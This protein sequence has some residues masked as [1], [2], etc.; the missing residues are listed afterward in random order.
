MPIVRD[1]RNDRRR[2]V[3]RENAAQAQASTSSKS[4]KRQA[5][6]RAD[7]TTRK[8]AG[9]SQ[10]VRQACGHRLVQLIPVRP[11]SFA[12]VIAVSL[13]VPALLSTAHY[14]VNVNGRLPWYGHP[15]AL[16]LDVNYPRSL[17]S[18]VT[19]QLWLLCLG[20]TILTFQLR[21]HK[22]DDYS[23]EYRL[24][25]WLVLTCIV[26]SLEASTGV[27]QL[28]S[29]ALDSWST[30][31]LGWSGPAIVKATLAVLIGMLGLRL[32][33]ELKSAPA[34]IVFVMI[35]LVAW[36]ISSALAQPEFQVNLSPQ[37]RIWAKCSLWLCGLTSIW[38]ASLTNL[39]HVYIEA[40]QRFLS[41]GRILSAGNS[42]PLSQRLRAAMPS[43]PQRGESA[44]RTAASG[45]DG[46]TSRW[47]LPRLRRSR[48]EVAEPATRTVRS[49]ARKPKEESAPDNSRQQERTEPGRAQPA[50][51]P[52][53]STRSAEAAGERAD[54][55]PRRGLGGFFKRGSTTDAL[56]TQEQTSRSSR[57]EPKQQREESR[58]ASHPEKR[59]RDE[60]GTGEKKPGR[61]TGWLRR[62]KHSEDAEE[63]RKI[64]R[65]ESRAKSERAS[66]VQSEKSES[67][68]KSQN[69]AEDGQATEKTPR[70]W[71]PR[72]PKPKM[73]KL[74][75]PSFGWLPK[76]SLSA[77]RLKPPAEKSKSEKPA[78]SQNRTSPSGKLPSTAASSPASAASGSEPD[79]GGDNGRPL[80]KAERK[81]LRR[82]QQQNRAA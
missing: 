24:W 11:L 71:V 17:A 16:V 53:T 64:P 2:R 26:G 38:L 59:K 58:Q 20:S 80:T 75:K 31:T 52:S 35:G 4:S 12:V 21:R 44:K 70:R 25:F 60:D 18:W 49:K 81:R 19:G 62:P 6:N 29:I 47:R 56:K 73:P 5:A 33:T 9:Y 45:E 10:D 51:T 79:D 40:Q 28:F 27:I 69:A 42:Q 55:N 23:G 14:L 48:D 72:V 13:L 43:L 54:T 57:A 82:M 34:S 15:L 1:P 65:E 36:A 22:L 68:S 37:V 74:K 32:C 30:T 3:L 77:L 78:A 8:G 39:R 41:R 66:R 61:L 7:G 67:R 50:A 63:F 76:I 46:E